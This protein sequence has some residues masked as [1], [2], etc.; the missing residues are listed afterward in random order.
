MNRLLNNRKSADL[1]WATFLAPGRGLFTQ[2][3]VERITTPVNPD[4]HHLSKK[5]EATSQ[6]QFHQ[7]V[8]EALSRARAQG[9]I[10]P[11][12]LG[13]IPFDTS[14]PSHL[15]IPRHYEFSYRDFVASEQ[16]EEHVHPKVSV[17]RCT[18]MPSD[19]RFKQG[20]H[21]AIANFQLSDIRKAVLGR[22]LDV[23]LDQSLDTHQVFE[24]LQQQNPAAYLFNLPL[25]GQEQLIG[26]SPELLLKKQGSHITSSPLAGSAKRHPDRTKDEAISQALLNSQKDIFEHKLVV[27]DIHAQL[28]DLCDHLVTPQGP[29]LMSTQT[30]WHLGSCI[31]G[32]LKY[33]RHSAL[34]IACRLHPTPAVCGFPTATARRLISL[35]EGFD[36]DVFAGMVG[37]SDAEGNGEW[38]VTIRC[39]IFSEKRV[40]LFAGAG[41]V[42]ASCAESEW[43]ETQAKLQTMLRALG[44]T[45]FPMANDPVD[46]GFS[47][48]A[49]QGQ[50]LTKAVSL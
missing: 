46:E 30:M 18:S 50:N 16:S 6:L 13:A 39:G 36:R 15:I 34:E 7:Q 28:K 26:A 41:I 8:E 10:K 49:A 4:I 22:I 43:A 12:I 1:P 25:N 31:H 3:V 32:Q 24:S 38:A 37:W 47:H 42:E 19:E 44:I 33:P 45:N 20:V 9:I 2:G 48:M 40:R 21:Q 11:I 23:E 29:S 27:D 17:K 5:S 35:V 14:K